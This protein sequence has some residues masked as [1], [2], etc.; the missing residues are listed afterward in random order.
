MMVQAIIQNI[1]RSYRME[2]L[3][4]PYVAIVCMGY[5]F[6][7]LVIF[8]KID[9]KVLFL[10]LLISIILVDGLRWEMGVDW[11]SYKAM[12]DKHVM[13]GVEFG[14]RLYVQLMSSVTNN[15]S[16]FTFLTAII[17]YVGN[18]GLLFYSTR[19]LVAVTFVLSTL[20][21]YSGSMRQFIA[22]G[23]VVGALYALTLGK[24][25][26]FLLLILMGSS[27]HI[28]AFLM[29][30]F[31]FFYGLHPLYVIFLLL[32]S[33]PITIFLFRFLDDLGPLLEIVFGSEKNFSARL[34]QNGGATEATNPV[35]G[36]L[37]K[38]YS[39]SVPIFFAV[40]SSRILGNK[41]I[42]FYGGVSTFSFLMYIIGVNYMQL[43]ASRMSYYF[44][45]L[46]FS[47]FIGFLDRELK[48]RT[49]RVVLLLFVISL[50]AI[51]YTRMSEFSLF[52]PYS[53][54]FYN[55]NL[56]RELY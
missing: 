9:K 55:T 17:V 24:K 41:K 14:F 31:L 21:W 5:I 34:N 47:F 11:E 20:P 40:T 30:P 49:N 2:F 51:T 29:I 53:S 6:S 12:F 50:S 32:V 1:S 8:S 46:A 3:M 33:F 15:Y 13:T 43:L 26:R 38:I 52:Y 16:I 48:G 28:T 19:S 54:V 10:I 27:F 42:L 35:L 7:F 56:S 22:S 23:F 45:V 37:R 25:W 18:L 4:H 44:S 36:F 39:F